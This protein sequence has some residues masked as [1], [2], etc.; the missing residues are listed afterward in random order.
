[1]QGAACLE[2]K[3]QLLFY[4]F[5]HAAS[6]LLAPMAPRKALEN[7]QYNLLV[8][9]ESGLPP[10]KL[11][12]QAPTPG[13]P[14]PKRP[15]RSR[16]TNI[17]SKPWPILCLVVLSLTILTKSYGYVLRKTDQKAAD[18]PL[19][20]LGKNEPQVAVSEMVSSKG[21]G[22]Q[23]QEQKGGGVQAR[24]QVTHI[25]KNERSTLEESRIRTEGDTL[26]LHAIPELK[27]RP[28]PK[29]LPPIEVLPSSPDT[30]AEATDTPKIALLFLTRGNLFHEPI[31]KEWFRSAAGV[32]PA[33]N[34][35]LQ[36]NLVAESNLCNK[37]DSNNINT[38]H[39]TDI[40]RFQHLFNVYIHAPSSFNGRLKERKKKLKSIVL[41]VLFCLI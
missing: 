7:I 2:A 34:A 10:R 23:E 13:K 41:L 21:V 29:T 19:N 16:L 18:L 28:W 22:K 24:K 30:C 33:K 8:S 17:S 32:L 25:K 37:R 26:L 27:K 40:I 15:T 14:G 6:L 39:D 38:V 35:A 1:M 12:L 36:Q 5:H 3:I 31:W 4:Y 20:N 9:A 11:L